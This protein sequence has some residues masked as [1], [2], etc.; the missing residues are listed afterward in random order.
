MIQEL[1][2]HISPKD[3]E[4]SVHLT[5]AVLSVYTLVADWSECHLLPDQYSHIYQG[6]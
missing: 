6:L 2:I 3:F 4:K 1:R 5:H